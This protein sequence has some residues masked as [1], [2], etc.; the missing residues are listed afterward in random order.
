[1]D[2]SHDVNNEV[3]QNCDA[4]KELTSSD[5]RPQE[6]S[7]VSNITS[8]IFVDAIKIHRDCVFHVIHV[9]V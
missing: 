5:S 2:T 4:E 1:M 3:E 7:S 9:E 8:K 6:E